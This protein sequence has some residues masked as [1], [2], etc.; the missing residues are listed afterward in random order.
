M[1]VMLIYI[2]LLMRYQMTTCN[3]LDFISQE[4][5]VLQ[6]YSWEDQNVENRRFGKTIK[7]INTDF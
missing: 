6:N 7:I 3:C 5:Q 4:Y 2:P 1:V